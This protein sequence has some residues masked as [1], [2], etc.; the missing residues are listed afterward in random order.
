MRSL[1]PI[2]SVARAAMCL[3]H[4]LEAQAALWGGWEPCRTR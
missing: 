1:P 3:Q 4:L 2:P